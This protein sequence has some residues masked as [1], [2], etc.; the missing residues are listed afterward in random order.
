[1]GISHETLKT[2]IRDYHGFELSDAELELVSP[3][4]D[5]YLAE[6]EKLRKLDLSGVVSARLLWADEGVQS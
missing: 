2:M 1:M 5:G 4:L 6:V 3:A